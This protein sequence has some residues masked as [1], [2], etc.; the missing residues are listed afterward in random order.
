MT[1][2][3]ITVVNFPKLRRP[4]KARDLVKEA[5]RMADELPGMDGYAI[6]AWRVTS[7]GTDT[8]ANY[9]SGNVP[10]PLVS[11]MVKGILDDFI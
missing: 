10:V 4:K 8:A 11:T 9:R 1:R 7:D 5:A 6:V 3:K 2:E